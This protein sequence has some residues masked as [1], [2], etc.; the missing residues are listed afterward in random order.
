M[1]CP[2]MNLFDPS[3][4]SLFTHHDHSRTR[5]RTAPGE[6]TSLFSAQSD[7]LLTCAHRPAKV[8]IFLLS[9]TPEFHKCATISSTGSKDVAAIERWTSLGALLLELEV[10]AAPQISVEGHN[11]QER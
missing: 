9:Q 3:P 4:R 7:E 5:P 8:P 10:N 2:N 1:S 11:N 6:T